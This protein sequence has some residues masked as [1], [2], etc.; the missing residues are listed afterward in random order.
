M[1]KNEAIR[2]SGGIVL[3]EP[4]VYITVYKLP[5]IKDIDGTLVSTIAMN[6]P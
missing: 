5:E 3:K 6:E 2:L 4:V 1:D